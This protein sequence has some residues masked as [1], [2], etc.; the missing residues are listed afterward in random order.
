MATQEELRQ[1]VARALE[2]N[3]YEAADVLKQ[4]YKALEA[5]ERS[6]YKAKTLPEILEELRAQ[7]PEIRG[8]FENIF[9]IGEQLTSG[10][11][12]SRG[13]GPLSQAALAGQLALTE[14]ILPTAGKSIGAVGSAAIQAVTPEPVERFAVETTQDMLSSVE[15][16]FSENQW[17]NKAMDLAKEKYEDYLAW[18][19]SSEEN[20]LKARELESVVDLGILALPASKVPPITHKSLSEISGTLIAEGKKGQA[21]Q[22]K[23]AVQELLEPIKIEKAPGDVVAVGRFDRKTYIPSPNEEEAIRIVSAIPDINPKRSEGYNLPIVEREISRVGNMLQLKINKSKNPSYDRDLLV[24]ELQKDLADLVGTDDFALRGGNKRFASAFLREAIKILNKQPDTA[25]GIL[26]ARKQIDRYADEIRPN[27]NDV[28]YGA[29]VTSEREVS[30]LL[31]DKLN[32]QLFQTVPD[33]DAEGLLRKQYLL[34][35]A[36]KT[37]REKFDAE[38]RTIQD[39]LRANIKRA[40]GVTVPATP[41]SLALTGSYLYSSGVLPYLS[42][43]AAVI[44]AGLVGKQVITSPSV[45]KGLGTLIAAT[46]KAIKKTENSAMLE[47]LKADRLYMIG[48]LNDLNAV[49]KNAQQEEE[50]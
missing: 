24:A 4:R 32:Q 48:L 20:T 28:T 27:I 11:L 47:Q 13:R 1:A 16:F 10:E 43:G 38:A 15:N 26:E 5:S 40:T 3:D 19:N 45:K 6:S 12:A 33:I 29:R 18:R 42:G 49:P 34:Y 46:D 21:L 37:L 39:R 50:E 25:L 22:K 2:A 44:G 30:K 14:S 7:G 41:L 8:T 35:G 36:K 17:A 9:N 31:R 23:P